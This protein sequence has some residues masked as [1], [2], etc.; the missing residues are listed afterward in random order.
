MGELIQFIPFLRKKTDTAMLARVASYT[1]IV[2]EMDKLELLEEMV[3]FQEK[4]LKDPKLSEENILR[5]MALF[6]NIILSAETKELHTLG[7]QLH[8]YLETELN[9]VRGI[10]P[11]DTPE[12]A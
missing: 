6:K 2:D 9:R 5:G 7:Q 10:S 3:R 12:T 8:S 11:K 4:K 1:E